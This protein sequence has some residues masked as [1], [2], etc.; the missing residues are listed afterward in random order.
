MERPWLRQPG[1]TLLLIKRTWCTTC[2]FILGGLRIPM[3]H[4]MITPI[5]RFGNIVCRLLLDSA[6]A[7]ADNSE[8]RITISKVSPGGRGRAPDKLKLTARCYAGATSSSMLRAT[9][10]WR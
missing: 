5:D 2:L 3:V 10:G 9:P 8:E 6:A 7:A 1:W 4:T